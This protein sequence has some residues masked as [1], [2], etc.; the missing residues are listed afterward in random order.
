M[1][2]PVVHEVTSAIAGYEWALTEG[3]GVGWQADALRP[4]TSAGLQEVV[5]INTT[6]LAPAPIAYGLAARACNSAGSCGPARRGAKLGDGRLGHDDTG[7]CAA[8]HAQG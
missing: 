4:W 5:Q 2:V 8:A 6:G 7:V 3:A 1:H